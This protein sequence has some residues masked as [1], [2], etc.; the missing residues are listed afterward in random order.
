MRGPPVTEQG[1]FLSRLAHL[2]EA[3][4]IPAMLTGSLASSFHGQPRTT[5]DVELVIAPTAGQLEKFLS[6]VGAD[7]VQ[8]E[9]LGREIREG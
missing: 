3:C 1:R 5:N 7:P 6:A 2:L 9:I 4:G 8:A